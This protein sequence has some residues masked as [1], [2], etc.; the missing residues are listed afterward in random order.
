MT[1]T[2]GVRDENLQQK[3]KS[4]FHYVTVSQE[5]TS[6]VLKFF[7]LLLSEAET[8]AFPVSRCIGALSLTSGTDAIMNCMGDVERVGIDDFQLIL[9]SMSHCLANSHDFLYRIIDFC[10]TVKENNG[11]IINGQKLECIE[12]RTMLPRLAQ[13]I[14][15]SSGTA[16][17]N[18]EYYEITHSK[19]GERVG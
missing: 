4:Y 10:L 16:Q 13:C 3:V 11:K 8:I 5:Y 18:H 1:G 7:F 6:I 2:N 9:E 14:N 15:A 12:W 17:G 19:L